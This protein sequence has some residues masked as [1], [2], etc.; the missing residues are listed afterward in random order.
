MRPQYVYHNPVLPEQLKHAGQVARVQS[1]G[2]YHGGDILYVL[3]GIPG[4]V[5]HEPCLEAV[6]PA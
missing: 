4:A 3:E 6:G 2:A 5:W 1:A